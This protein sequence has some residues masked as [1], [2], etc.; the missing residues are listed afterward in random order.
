[1][2]ANVFTAEN[3]AMLLIDH[4]IGTISWT[5]SHRR[6][7]IKRNA[8]SLAK[9]AKA[10][11][12]PL[13]LTSSQ[14]ENIQGPLI[15]ELEK[16]APV[17]FEN[18]IRRS[19]IVNAMHDENFNAAVRA[20]GR[21]KIIVAGITSEVCVVFPVLQLLDEGYEV[22]VVADAS[23]GF[24]RS[25]HDSSLRRVEQAGAVIVVTPQIISELAIDWTTPQGQELQKV[26]LSGQSFSAILGTG[27]RWLTAMGP[28]R[29]TRALRR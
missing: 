21:K 28:A 8:I 24:T 12:M 11:D 1:M 4:Q 29:V 26:L 23:A 9:I 14:E 20:T 18:R 5:T 19:G 17:E 10:F 27:W 3:A 15:P 16:A 13:L 25:G 7:D 6:G 2:H 22:Q